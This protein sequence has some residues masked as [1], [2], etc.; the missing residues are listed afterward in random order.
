MS[1]LCGSTQVSLALSSGWGFFLDRC[2]F[3]S[4]ER[5]MSHVTVLLSR[6]T[7][8]LGGKDFILGV[9]LE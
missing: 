1:S 7:L 8:P 6:A 9:A 4:K 5:K 2:F 3:L